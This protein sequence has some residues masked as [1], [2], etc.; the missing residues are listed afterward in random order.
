MKK[1]QFFFAIL[2]WLIALVIAGAIVAIYLA[3]SGYF[4]TSNPKTQSSLLSNAFFIPGVLLAGAGLLVMIAN[5]GTFN[6]LSYALQTLLS[7]FFHNM[8]T[9]GMDY[10]TYCEFKSSKKKTPYLFLL[11]TGFAF[12]V[13]GGIFMGVY[14]NTADPEASSSVAALFIR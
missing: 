8:K 1:K 7:R 12:I 2:P 4:V 9:A 5:E 11:L 6:F 13:V 10:G 14:L 3:A